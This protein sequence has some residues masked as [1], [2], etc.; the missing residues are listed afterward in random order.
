MQ[1][2]SCFFFHFSFIIHMCIQGYLVNTM[3]TQTLCITF[4]SCES[5]AGE[6]DSLAAEFGKMCVGVYRI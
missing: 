5:E 3:I 2:Y 1:E 4:G 6:L